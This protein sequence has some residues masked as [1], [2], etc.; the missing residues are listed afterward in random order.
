MKM[1]RVCLVIVLA[2][3]AVAICLRPLV[4]TVTRHD[5]DTSVVS[6]LRTIH[7]AQAQFKAIRG[8]FGTLKELADIGLIGQNFAAGTSVAQYVY[9]DVA[10][11]SESYCVCANRANDKAGKRDFNIIEDG[12]VRYH[13]SETKDSAICGKGKSLTVSLESK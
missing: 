10:V 12:E 5:R 6:S 8:R 1:F 11:S 3:M 4:S 9:T 13:E 2:L 7:N